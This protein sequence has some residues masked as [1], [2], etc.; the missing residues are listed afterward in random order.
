MITCCEVAIV[1]ALTNILS[2]AIFA[3]YTVHW[4]ERTLKLE[5]KNGHE[6]D[7]IDQLKKEVERLKSKKSGGDKN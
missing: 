7:Q 4:K 6:Q 3:G 2:L 1:L 5:K